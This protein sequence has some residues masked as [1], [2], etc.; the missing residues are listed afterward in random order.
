MRIA[1]RQNCTRA[2]NCTKI[3]LHEDKFVRGG[4][5]AQRCKTA[6]RQFCKTVNFARVTI[7]HES[8]EKTEKLN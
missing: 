5:I 6:R 8:K 7:L 1:Q 2:Q 4:K 3:L